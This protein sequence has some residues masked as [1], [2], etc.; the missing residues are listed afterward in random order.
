[1]GVDEKSIAK[2]HKY[3]SL[4]YDM[5]AGTVELVWDDRGRESLE[6]YFRQFLRKELDEIQAV[7]MDMG[8]PYIAATKKHVPEAEKKIVS[9]RFHVMRHVLKAVDEVRKNEN[10]Y[11][12]ELGVSP[13]KGTKYLWLWSQENVPVWRQEEFAALRALDLKVCRAW[14]MKETLRRMW[15]YRVATPMR[16]FFRR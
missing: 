3:E 5:D 15:E 4:V 8:D 10:R 9:D 11:L 13:L 2:G 14:A 1:M 7:A 12:S 16:K 6:N